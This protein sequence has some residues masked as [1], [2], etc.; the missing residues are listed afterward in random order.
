MKAFSASLLLL[1][2][3]ASAAIPGAASTVSFDRNYSDPA[4]DVV[5]LWT[6]NMTP[7]LLPDGNLTLTP[8]PDSVNLLRIRSANVSASVNLTFQVKGSIANLDNTTYEMRL[9]TRLDN[10]SHFIVTYVNGS[11]VLTSNA[12]GFNPVDISGNSAIVSTG[13]NPALLNTLVL[14]VAKSLLGP[15][16]SWDIDATATQRGLTYTYRDYGWA[17]SGSPGSGPPSS[18]FGV[19]LPDWIWLAVAPVVIAIAVVIFVLVRHQRSGRE[20]PAK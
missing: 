1:A 10:A 6:S 7:V 16:T 2:L 14:T 20:P 19:V 15:I 17:V 13:S 18:Q 5:Q 3:I 8:F 9:Y 12:T 4:S 11:T